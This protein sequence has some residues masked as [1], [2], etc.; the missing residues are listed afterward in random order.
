M[1]II[2]T[3]VGT[4]LGYLMWLCYKLF[5]DYGVAI[6][7]F[8]L[9]TKV[10]MFPISLLVQK[11][12]IKMVKM[13]PELDA[14]KYQYVDDQDAFID[15]QTA[16]YKREKYSPM[17]GVWPLL[18]QLPIIFGLIDVVY[19]P[20]KHL[21][22][23]PSDVIN[24]FT[25]KASEIL[26]VT[27]L[28]SSPQLRVVELLSQ[29]ENIPK[30]MELQGT[31]DGVDV[32]GAI[33]TIRGVNMN[34]LGINLAATPSVTVLNLLFLVPVLAGLS[35]LIMCVIQNRINVLQIEQ[36]KLS[37]WGMTLFMIAFSTYFA[38]IV[39]AGVG[40]YW[41]WGNLF[42]IGVMY[43]VNV[44]Y[45]PKKYIDY[46]ALA[47]LKKQ[48]ALDKEKTKRNKKMAKKYY[49]AF[50]RPENIEKMK[51]MFYAEGGG[52]Y[53]YFQNI[54]EALLQKT[55]KLKIHYV[56]S[57]PQDP[58]LNTKE[59]RIIPY[60]V[61]ENRL[62]SLMM[63]V[64]AKMVVMTTPDLEKYHIKRSRVRKDV[65]Y[66]YVDHGCSSLNLTYR[67][68]AFDYFDTIFAVSDQQARE[69]R[70][71][72]QLR[73]T[74]EKKIVECGYGLLDNM[75]EAYKALPPA[76]NEKKTILIA[77]SW[78]YD[79]IMDS[80]LDDLVE[81]LTGSGYRIV[82]RP[83]PQ[84]VRRFPLKIK[85]I[86]N[87]YADRFSD[88]FI[89]ETDFS[90]NVTVYTADLLITDWSAISF[91]FSFTTNKPTLFIN[92]K[93]KVVNKAYKK[94][95]I[96]PFDITAREQVG[97]SIDKDEVKNIAAVADDLLNNQSLYAA[98]IEKLKNEYF[99]HLGHSGEAGADY[100]ISR[101]SK[102]KKHAEP[103][104]EPTAEQNKDHSDE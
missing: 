13:K 31:L 73:G 82:I 37:Q 41:M 17:A 29:N 30:F 70:A 24:A 71:I 3:I 43:L 99:Y 27:D 4:P 87:Q 91:E 81:G 62:I 72:E 16:L 57:D 69:V 84:Y 51:L 40:L 76:E 7:F 98:G 79:N 67:T 102:K 42:S 74:P 47:D 11:N 25:Q 20:L 36:N 68:G 48:T 28:G 64:E 44:I 26:G 88:D 93:M 63:K 23:M 97:R 59:E 101:L 55:T 1:E 39:P 80:C 5:H 21:L 96:E 32:N 2:N 94:I 8:T 9:L 22:H 78:Q 34:F 35:A 10:V 60:Y 103:V 66:V 65:E 15:A 49:K 12:S 100:I 38:F 85:E 50:C 33:E 14:L 92:T 75:I 61:D 58:I 53:K 90:S 56:T 19:K 95:D 45:N 86:L 52:Y 77:P 54:I 83:H 46:A 104:S 18:L 6:I 89:I